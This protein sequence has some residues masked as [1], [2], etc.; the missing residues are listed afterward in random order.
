MK[1]LHHQSSSVFLVPYSPHMKEAAEL[2]W[3][4]VL[5]YPLMAQLGEPQLM[6]VAD[7]GMWRKFLVSFEDFLCFLVEHQQL[8]LEDL[9]QLKQG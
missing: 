1:Y 9:P 3:C 7:D 5:D 6:E 8:L 2:Y 4:W